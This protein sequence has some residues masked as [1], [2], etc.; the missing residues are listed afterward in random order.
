M[1]KDIRLKVNEIFEDTKKKHLQTQSRKKDYLYKDKMTDAI[2]N[3]R[4]YS[5]KG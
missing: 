4:S 3:R 5:R 2:S 1:D